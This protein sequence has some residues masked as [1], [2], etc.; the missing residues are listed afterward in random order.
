LLEVGARFEAEAVDI[1]TKRTSSGEDFH[2]I[3]PKGYEPALGL[4]NCE[5]LTENIAV[6]VW[7]AERYPQLRRNGVLSRTRQLEMLAFISTEIH[8]AFKPLWHG[9]TEPETAKTARGSREPARIRGH[10][11]WP[12]IISSAMNSPLRTAIFT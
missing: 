9:G 12:A 11:D 3:N 10:A 1:G 8:R 2:A 6:L 4:D 7:I 5:T